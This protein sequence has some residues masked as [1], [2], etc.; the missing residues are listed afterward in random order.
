MKYIVLTAIV[1][2]LAL[3]STADAW[4]PDRQPD[5]WMLMVAP[6]H[7]DMSVENRAVQL[8]TLY[9]LEDCEAI[10]FQYIRDAHAWCR[11]L[12]IEPLDMV[13]EIEVHHAN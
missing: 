10:A 1:L 11:P 4:N 6:D 5:G 12:F 3:H 2:F 7:T 8:N 9:T 13:Q